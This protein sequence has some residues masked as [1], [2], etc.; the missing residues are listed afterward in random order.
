MIGINTPS[1]QPLT[2]QDHGIKCYAV[3]NLDNELMGTYPSPQR[4]LQ[5]VQN[6]E[7]QSETPIDLELNFLPHDRYEIRG[8]NQTAPL[9]TVE[10][11]TLRL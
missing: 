10:P 6:W 3:L 1:T 11:T 9:Y 2:Y 5:Y 4:A 7:N 8:I